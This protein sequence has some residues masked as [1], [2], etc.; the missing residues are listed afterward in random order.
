MR[1]EADV[2]RDVG[3]IVLETVAGSTYLDLRAIRPDE[4]LVN[5]LGLPA[6]Q[7]YNILDAIDRRLNL[8]KSDGIHNQKDPTIQDIINFYSSCE[9]NRE[10][11]GLSG[12]V[13][14][15]VFDTLARKTSRTIDVR[16]TDVFLVRDLGFTPQQKHEALRSIERRLEGSKPRVLLAQPDCTIEEIICFHFV[17]AYKRLS[18]HS[19]RKRVCEF[20]SK[21]FEPK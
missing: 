9:M 21:W 5:G 15:I 16:N 8:D 11:A 6:K 14:G 7:V 1:A 4:P 2:K 10:L 18:R 17:D 12:H 19:L 3:Q 20:L 13:T